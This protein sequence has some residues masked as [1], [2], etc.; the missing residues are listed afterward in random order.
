MGQVSYH[1]P[2]DCDDNGPLT[3]HALYLVQWNTLCPFVP[4]IHLSLCRPASAAPHPLM[5]QVHTLSSSSGSSVTVL[6]M[7]GTIDKDYPR[8][9]KGYAFEI[10]EPAAGRVLEVQA[11]SHHLC[12]TS[13]S[14]SHLPSE[15]VPHSPCNG[16]VVRR[17]HIRES[18]T[19]STAFAVRTPRSVL[20][21]HARAPSWGRPFAWLL[22]SRTPGPLSQE[23]TDGDREALCSAI[24]K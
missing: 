16:R 22:A 4:L 19:R 6:G 17:C 21:S 10:D 5:L 7:G 1:R 23:I 9:T 13:Q 18:L 15:P 12:C 24:R 3:A 20:T 2:S 8:T 11:I 14:L